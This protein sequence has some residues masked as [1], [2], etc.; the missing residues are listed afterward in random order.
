MTWRCLHLTGYALD[1]IGG[2]FHALCPAPRMNAKMDALCNGS[3]QF[4]LGLHA[5]EEMLVGDGFVLAVG[6]A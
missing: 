5:T 2:V 3:C 4:Q 6:G 1:L